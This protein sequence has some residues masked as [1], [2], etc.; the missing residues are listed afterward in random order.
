[1][2]KW[3]GA[4]YTMLTGE[5]HLPENEYGVRVEG[6]GANG[7]YIGDRSVP[8]EGGYYTPNVR[9]LVAVA[10]GGDVEVAVSLEGILRFCMQHEPELVE[11]VRKSLE[12]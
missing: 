4:D 5:I 7:A 1:M 8:G 3:A 12:A 6:D 11:Q 10:N 2:A 9:C